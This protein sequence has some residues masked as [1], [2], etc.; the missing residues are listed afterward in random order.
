MGV[1]LS[2]EPPSGPK[3]P[4]TPERILRDNGLISTYEEEV[5]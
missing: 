2:K 1:P 3:K 5:V 4:L